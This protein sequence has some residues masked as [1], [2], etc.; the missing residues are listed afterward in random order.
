MKQDDERIFDIKD[1]V[2]RKP[3]RMDGKYHKD[4]CE[5]SIDEI[6]EYLPWLAN[7]SNWSLKQHQAYMQ[8]LG[9]ERMPESTRSFW[10]NGELVGMGHL[11]ISDWANSGELFYW[12]TTGFDG[13][14]LGEHIA[15]TMIKI[16]FSH[17]PYHHL[18]IKTDRDNV[19]SKRIMEKV[20]AEH[21]LYMGYT[22]HRNKQSNM[23]LWYLDSPLAKAMGRYDA[24]YLFNP[25]SA[26][27]TN[28]RFQTALDP[29]YSA[30]SD[31][32]LIRKKNDN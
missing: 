16:G 9:K 24:K 19:G 21:G 14:G 17:I 6:G 15:R 20:G 10:W 31:P 29:D 26:G 8:K 28:V 5:K 27:V 23:V 22:T 32:S 4:A 2:N 18:V 30:V 7:S 25:L 11:R 1:V 3:I 13:L 12:V